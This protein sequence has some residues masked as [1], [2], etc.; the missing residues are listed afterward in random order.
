MTTKQQHTLDD[1]V[2]VEP[3]PEPV[4]EPLA[5][6]SAAETVIDPFT[7]E[8]L[9]GKDW[10]EPQQDWPHQWIDYKG[11]RLA[12]RKPTQMGMAGFSLGSSP[13]NNPVRRNNLTGLFMSLHMADGTWWRV[14]GRMMNPDEVDYALES[15][16]DLVRQII[17]L[18]TDNDGETS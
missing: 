14:H 11:D 9:V 8:A 3:E 15:I 6:L 5:S 13:H 10:T 4:A 18:T 17:E 16:G 7:A 2:L 1:A 12:V